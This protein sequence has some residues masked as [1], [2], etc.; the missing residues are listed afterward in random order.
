MRVVSFDSSTTCTGVVVAEIEN[1][2]LNIVSL[3]TSAI[4]P[5]KFDVLDLGY[6]GK[7]RK[8]VINH[9]K[10]TTSTTAWLVSVDE[11][12]NMTEKRKRDTRVRL[13]D[14]AYRR[15]Y[16]AVG[17]NEV[18][19]AHTDVVL[20]EE[21]MGFR[22]QTVTRKLAEISGI[23]QGA[24]AARKLV[25][26]KINV[27]TAR[28]TLDIVNESLVFAQGKDPAWLRNCDLTK[29]VVKYLMLKKYDSYNLFEDMTTDETDALLI[30]D[31]WYT[32]YKERR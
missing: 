21:N 10:T 19:V 7:K 29:E 32:S 25:V 11:K 9:S 6:L 30:F 18:L 24:A 1:K 17:I 14:E 2:N 12:I 16:M 22:S 15:Y 28:A 20:M 31:T 23:I 27:H 8:V 4:R 5:E 26:S 13:A 3:K